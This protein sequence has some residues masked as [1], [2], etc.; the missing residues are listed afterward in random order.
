[1]GIEAGTQRQQNERNNFKTKIGRLILPFS[2][3]EQR[4]VDRD[5]AL[6]RQQVEDTLPLFGTYANIKVKT[7][8][9]L[10]TTDPKKANPELSYTAFRGQCGNASNE[11]KYHMYN[12]HHVI[13]TE[14]ASDDNLN[15]LAEH[16]YLTTP[17]LSGEVLI[18]PTIGQYI[19]GHNHIF[20]GTR[21]QLKK[22]VEKQTGKG[23]KY[24]LSPLARDRT[25]SELFLDIWGNR[26]SRLWPASYM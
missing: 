16:E 18:D 10:L 8:I 14:V 13:V 23:K 15:D 24:S 22:V 7:L 21:K 26:S 1:M 25:P 20:V 2:S 19:A 9:G 11:I 6:V 17:T 4:Q 12:L 3:E 5:V